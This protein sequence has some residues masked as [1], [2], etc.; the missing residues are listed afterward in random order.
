MEVKITRYHTPEAG[1]L[2]SI[3]DLARFSYTNFH[4]ET[5]TTTGIVMKIH[6]E[7]KDNLHK[8]WWRWYGGY[9]VHSN[10]GRVYFVEPG[11][12]SRLAGMD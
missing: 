11:L 6:T 1:P 12:I 8:D 3:G 9:T 4:G 5:H 2:L 7:P 10:D